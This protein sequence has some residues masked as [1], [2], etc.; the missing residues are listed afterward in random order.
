MNIT[1]DELVAINQWRKELRK[2]LAEMNITEIE[3]L[4][5]GEAGSKYNVPIGKN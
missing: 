5:Y 2:A 4:W 3:R 1:A